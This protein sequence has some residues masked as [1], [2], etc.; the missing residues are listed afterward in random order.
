MYIHKRLLAFKNAFNGIGAATKSEAHMKIHLLASAVVI[1]AGFSFGITATEWCL[2]LLCCGLVIGLE[3]INSAIERLTDGIY[4]QTCDQAKY[5]K[6]VA[7]GAVLIAALI[8]GIT[9]GII[10]CKYIL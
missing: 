7:A 4:T 2:L 3:M 10:F 8:S 6:D 1:V 9:G 5:I